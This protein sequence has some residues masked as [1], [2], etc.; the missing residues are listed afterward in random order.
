FEAMARHCDPAREK[1]GVIPD[2][3]PE[4]FSLTRQGQR[5][6][7]KR[8]RRRKRFATTSQRMRSF[9]PIAAPRHL[10]PHAL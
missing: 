1:C 5:Q 3:Y 7:R 6:A 9:V 10:Q 2:R 8:L 4:P